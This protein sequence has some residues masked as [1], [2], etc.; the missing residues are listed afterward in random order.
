VGR[1]SNRSGSER[2]R[3]RLILAE[4]SGV[5]GRH[6]SLS[7]SYLRGEQAAIAEVRAVG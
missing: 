7:G 2:E 1:R 4:I 6:M 5:T 3:E